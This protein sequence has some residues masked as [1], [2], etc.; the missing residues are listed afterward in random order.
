MDGQ[1]CPA[2]W[3]EK[4]ILPGSR[5]VSWAYAMPQC[6]LQ[7]IY[8]NWIVHMHTHRT[9]TFTQILI[10]I[11]TNALFQIYIIL[12]FLDFSFYYCFL[13]EF[14]IWCWEQPCV[15]FWKNRE[16]LWRRGE[17]WREHC[18]ERF[19]GPLGGVMVGNGSWKI[20]IFFL[21]CLSLWIFSICFMFPETN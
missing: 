12:N 4:L 6:F 20:V 2:G 1:L 15:S 3:V 19:G 8:R 13:F 18:M 17:R 5:N 7:Y 21:T 14:V 10:Q 9:F 16:G 11:V